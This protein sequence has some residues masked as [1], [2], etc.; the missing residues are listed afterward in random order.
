MIKQKH[1]QV[2]SHLTFRK[3]ETDKKTTTTITSVLLPPQAIST[4]SCFSP[5]PWPVTG[6][7]E[8]R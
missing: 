6:N 8:S 1:R 5:L 7:V 3:E 4:V 2:L